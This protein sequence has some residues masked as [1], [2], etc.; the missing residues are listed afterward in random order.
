MTYPHS[1]TLN[2]GPN[3][4]TRPVEAHHLT[5]QRLFAVIFAAALL[6]LVAFGLYAWRLQ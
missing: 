2:E 5:I 3:T 1:N 4:S 6:A